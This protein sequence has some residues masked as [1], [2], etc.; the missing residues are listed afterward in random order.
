MPKAIA[1]L[2]IVIA[3]PQ[4]HI[5]SLPPTTEG[6]GVLLLLLLLTT[7]ITRG[8][9]QRTP[10]L[11][12]GPQNCVVQNPARVLA[13]FL[14]RRRTWQPIESRLDQFSGTNKQ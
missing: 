6:Q 2:R 1:R 12:V 11:F 3:K 4:D 5:C 14:G 8:A 10:D 13:P 7:Q 9:L